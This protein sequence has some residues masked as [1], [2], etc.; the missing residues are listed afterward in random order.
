[1]SAAERDLEREDLPEG[2]DAG[3]EELLRVED[4]VIRYVTDEGIV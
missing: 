1:M 2:T 3:S 4:L